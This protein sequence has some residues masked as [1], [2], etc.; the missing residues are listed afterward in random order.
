[1]KSSSPNAALRELRTLVSTYVG[2]SVDA[3]RAAE[4]LDV[5]D[6]CLMP[7]AP[8]STAPSAHELE[9]ERA[10]FGC[11]TTAIDEAL[12]GKEPR[13][14]AV[15]AMGTLSNA[16]ELIRR[17]TYEGTVEW[18]V[19]DRDANTIRQFI[20]IAKYAIDKAVPR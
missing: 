20:N 18:S 5:L 19:A 10:M 7:V 16:Q 6:A 9:R 4:L 11:T 3:V 15:H 8:A 2:G 13:D 14:V 12:S 17:D 1:M